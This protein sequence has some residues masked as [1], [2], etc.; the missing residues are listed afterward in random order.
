[1]STTITTEE[2]LR[3][4]LNVG[5]SIAQSVEIQTILD[6]YDRIAALEGQ[7]AIASTTEMFDATQ[8]IVDT[9]QIEEPIRWIGVR[10]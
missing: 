6:L 3:Q 9:G 8:K 5:S 7:L 10:E 1:M 2:Y 4:C